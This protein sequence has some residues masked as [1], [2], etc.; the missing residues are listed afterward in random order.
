MGEGKSW[1][2]MSARNNGPA[3]GVSVRIEEYRDF[4]VVEYDNAA[5]PDVDSGFGTLFR[6]ISKDNQKRTEKSA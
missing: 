1:P 2:N 5:D 6:Y 4:Y 3:V